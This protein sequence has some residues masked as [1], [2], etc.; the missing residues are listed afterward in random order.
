MTLRVNLEIKKCVSTEPTLTL[1]LAYIYSW[2]APCLFLRPGFLLASMPPYQ[3]Q[4]SF[5]GGV[6][7]RGMV[8]CSFG[9]SMSCSQV[10]LNHLA[11]FTSDCHFFSLHRPVS[12]VSMQKFQVSRVLCR[13]RSKLWSLLYSTESVSHDLVGGDAILYSLYT[14]LYMNTSF[15]YGPGFFSFFI[16][17][18]MIRDKTV[19]FRLIIAYDM[20]WNIVHKEI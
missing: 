19:L 13:A 9:G 6:Y 3:Q 10:L 2:I 12:N 4:A 20:I 15:H 7:G 11:A 8:L 14:S 16:V 17:G 18:V 5:A 1:H